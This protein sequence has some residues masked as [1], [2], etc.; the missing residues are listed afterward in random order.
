MKPP[1]VTGKE[2]F[3]LVLGWLSLILSVYFS[4]GPLAV[5]GAVQVYSSEQMYQTRIK[6][7]DRR[8]Q[9]RRPL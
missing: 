8:E 3:G 7:L 9:M 2:L 6:Y 4:S 1:E 5:V